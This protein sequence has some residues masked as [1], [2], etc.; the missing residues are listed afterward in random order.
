MTLESTAERN[1]VV[2][3]VVRDQRLLV[4]RRAECVAAPGMICFPGGAIE[5]GED[6]PTALVRE[7]QEELDVTVRPLRRLWSSIAPWKVALAWWLA[8]LDS[9]AQIQPNPLE[10][11][12]AA[13][14]TIGNLGQLPDLLPSNHDFL[15]A[16]AKGEFSLDLA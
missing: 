16:L 11:A 8:D 10:V 3:V 6:E 4:I 13:W 15:A 12:E 14:L 2:G 9:A 7:F 1:G 5:S